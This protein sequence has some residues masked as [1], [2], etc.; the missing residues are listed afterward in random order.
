MGGGSSQSRALPASPPPAPPVSQE[1]DEVRSA[2]DRERRRI[3]RLQGRESTLLVS[4]LDDSG[5]QTLGE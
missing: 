4:P 2:Y 3:A 1:D 5:K